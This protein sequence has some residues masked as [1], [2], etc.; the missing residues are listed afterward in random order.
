MEEVLSKYYAYSFE[1]LEIFKATTCE[2][3]DNDDF[4]NSPRYA[5]EWLISQ[6]CMDKSLFR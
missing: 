1:G 6:D 4:L 3:V 2:F 5:L